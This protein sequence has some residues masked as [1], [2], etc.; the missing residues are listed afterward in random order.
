MRNSRRTFPRFSAAQTVLVV[1][2]VRSTVPLFRAGVDCGAATGMTATVQDGRWFASVAERRLAPL[3]HAERRQ[4]LC[5]LLLTT[6][7]YTSH[8]GIRPNHHLGHGYSARSQTHTADA[9]A[10][11]QT[12]RRRSDLRLRI[13]DRRVRTAAS[14]RRANG[15]V[16]RSPR[17]KDWLHRRISTKPGT[18]CTPQLD[19]GVCGSEARIPDHHFRTPSSARRSSSKSDVYANRRGSMS[20]RSAEIGTSRANRR[21]LSANATSCGRRTDSVKI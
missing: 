11:G 17:R 18:N 12:I 19:A 2:Q 1:N 7:A 9:S 8:P 13:E 4:S 14:W 16:V 21:W 20:V 15:R 3:T 6:G 5:S 10:A